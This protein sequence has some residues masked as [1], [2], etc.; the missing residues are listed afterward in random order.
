[1]RRKDREIQDM[2]EIMEILKR[3]SVCTVGFQDTAVSFYLI[4]MNYGALLEEGKPALYFHG[5]AGGDEVR[6]FKAGSP[7]V[8]YG[9]YRR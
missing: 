1:M 9:V 8:L 2:A 6:A 4:P 7:C 5:A 3:G